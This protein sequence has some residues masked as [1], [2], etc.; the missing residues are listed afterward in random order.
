MKRPSFQFYPADYLA[1]MQLRMLPWASKGLYMDMLCYCWRE[2]W[3]PSDSSAIA[4]L[5]GCH[6]LAIVEPC[7]KLFQVDETDPSKMTHKRLNEEKIKQD[8][9]RKERSISGKKGAKTRWNKGSRTKVSQNDS[10]ANSSAIKEPIAKNSSSTS[11]SSSTS[12]SKF[13]IPTIDEVKIHIQSVSAN[14]DPVKFHSYYESNGWMVGKN[15]MKSWKAAVTSWNKNS[16][17]SIRPTNE[18]LKYQQ[19]GNQFRPFD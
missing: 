13:I 12:S 16:S 10:S 19:N 1:D 18:K 7:K 14:V 2:G 15:K 11:T 4:Q 8:E 6:D 3:I 17:P 9:H 5:C